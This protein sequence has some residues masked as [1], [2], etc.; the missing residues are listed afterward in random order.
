MRRRPSHL[1]IALIVYGVLLAGSAPLRADEGIT[2]RAIVAPLLVGTRSPLLAVTIELD[3][4]RTI[5]RVLAAGALKALRLD[6]GSGNPAGLLEAGSHRLELS[7]ELA[8]GADLL[9]PIGLDFEGLEFTDG[10]TLRAPGQHRFRAG[11]PIHQQGE[12]DCHTTRI[13][14]IARTNSGTLLAVYDL[15]YNSSK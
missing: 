7:G 1:A 2:T 5:K 11:Y 3:G 14:G 10:T 12:H 13:P 9:T 6:E 4:P 8:G 15:R